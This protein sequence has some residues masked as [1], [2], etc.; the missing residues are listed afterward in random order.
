MSSLTI[1]FT[2]PNP[3]PTN[4]Y[5]VQYRVKGSSDPYLLLP[6]PQTGSPIVISGLNPNTNYEGTIS[7]N[8]G[9]GTSPLVNFQT[10][11]CF[12]P[13][14]Y[15]VS[16]DASYCYQELSQDAT[17]TGG[18]NPFLACHFNY[19]QYS[20]YG[21]VF[22]K[23]GGYNADGSWNTPPNIYTS[24]GPSAVPGANV[25]NHTTGPLIN[26]AQDTVSG[27]LN[28]SGLWVCGNQN[29]GG[30]LGFS[31]QFNVQ[32]SK[33]YYVGLGADNYAS[34]AFNGNT[35]VSQD[36]GA[37]GAQGQFG[38]SSGSFMFRFWHMYPVQLQSGINLIQIQGSNVA[39]IGVFGC[40]IYDATEDQL[41]ACNTADDLAQY[42]V[43]STK[44]VPDNGTFDTGNYSCSNFPGS[45]LVYDA[46]A[47]TYTCKIINTATC[48]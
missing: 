26:I 23:V 3:L 34:I 11:Q 19:V 4:G 28:T 46:G 7:S 48:S 39:G 45:Q 44:D 47:N 40:E 6:E 27:R 20:M 17:Y 38:D 36:V 29:Y 32:T 14:G 8:C 42:I 24:L 16:P 35:I 15:S 22:Y 9:Y 10:N 5:I 43:F 21:P 41:M 25:I 18:S 13:D 12:C 30:T 31:R 2:P 37:M 1:S 33:V